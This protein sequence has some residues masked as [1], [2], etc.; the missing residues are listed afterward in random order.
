[1][2]RLVG[3]VRGC[4]QRSR[5]GR[6]SGSSTRT[7]STSAVRLRRRVAHVHVHEHVHEDGANVAVAAD[8]WSGQGSWAAFAAGPPLRVEY[9]D[10][11]EVRARVRVR[12]WLCGRALLPGMGGGGALRSAGR[13]PG[14]VTMV[15]ADCEYDPRRGR[16]PGSF[17]GPAR[18]TGSGAPQRSAHGPPAA[19][20][21]AHLPAVTARLAHGWPNT[22]RSACPMPV[23]LTMAANPSR[24]RAASP[25]PYSCSC[26]CSCSTR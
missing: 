1:M 4:G 17:A 11:Y 25:T 2:R 26:S 14:P 13:A 12:G 19:G 7:K 3:R 24:R 18:V 23:L 21:D 9:E 8:S 15:A 16:G 5:R 6:H 22:G 20:E 10:E